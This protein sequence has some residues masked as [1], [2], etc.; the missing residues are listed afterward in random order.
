MPGGGSHCRVG[1][2]VGGGAVPADSRPKSHVVA[3]GPKPGALH[4]IL[5]VPAPPGCREDRHSV[6][7]ASTCTDARDSSLRHLHILLNLRAQMFGIRALRTPGMPQGSHLTGGALD[8]RGDSDNSEAGRGFSIAPAWA[9]GCA[10][11]RTASA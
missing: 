10:R 6:P 5:R 7:F 3:R 11:V 2:G 4:R 1:V 8:T 9:S